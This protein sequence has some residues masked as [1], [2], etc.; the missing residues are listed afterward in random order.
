MLILLADTGH[1]AAATADGA[2]AD[3]M[4]HALRALWL[5]WVVKLAVPALLWTREPGWP[6]DHFDTQLLANQLVMAV[7]ALLPIALSFSRQRPMRWALIVV[8]CLWALYF[9]LSLVAGDE[10]TWYVARLPPAIGLLTS[11]LT[12][13]WA[14]RQ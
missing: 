12:V 7:L 6:R 13:R 1:R 2:V 8:S 9:F 3:D 14:Q 5:A 4:I 11:V 10:G